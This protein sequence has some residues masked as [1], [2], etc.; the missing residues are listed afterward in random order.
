MGTVYIRSARVKAPTTR[1]FDPMTAVPRL[2]FAPLWA[3]AFRPFCA[4]GAAYG[5]LIVSAWTASRAGLIALPF[6]ALPPFMWHAHEMLF[7]FAV[8]IICATV[9]TA[10]PGWAGTPEVT[11]APLACLVALWLAGRV[12]AWCGDAVSPALAGVPDALLYI[13]LIVLLAPQL[14]RVE[15]RRYLALLV[16]LGGLFAGQVMFA[17]GRVETG[18]LVALYAV[19]LVFVLKAGVLTPVFTGNELRVRGRGDQAAF[20]PPLEYAAVASIVVLAALHLGGAPRAW[21]GMAA[22]IAFALHAVRFLRWRGWKVVDSPML[23]SMHAGYAWMLCALVL[24]ALADFGVAA[25]ARAW[26]H[27]FTVGA[28]G[29]MMLGLMTRIALR[30]TGRPLVLPAAMVAAYALLLVAAV[31]RV[32][33][34]LAL[35]GLVWVVAAGVTWSMAFA[36]YL[37]CFGPMLV[38]P[39]L[40]RVA[41]AALAGDPRAQ[42][43]RRAR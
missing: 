40:P 23:A 12:A 34:A 25:A 8:A 14:A 27:A 22:L 31:L 19:L 3:S 16:V 9:L 39:S 43:M 15:N 18:F 7:G 6:G 36:L 11:G 1:A 17:A 21:Q 35:P 30:H 4:L 5:V 38:T 28:L 37:V 20:V 29:S 42:P 33:A 2:P 41:P 24:L 10:L 26:V 32:G 13:V